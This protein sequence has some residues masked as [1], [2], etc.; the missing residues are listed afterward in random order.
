[1]PSQLAK[2][3]RYGN[4]LKKLIVFVLASA[5]LLT[6]CDIKGE[7]VGASTVIN[8]QCYTVVKNHEALHKSPT[9]RISIK[10]SELEISH[11]WQFHQVTNKKVQLTDKTIEI[12]YQLNNSFLKDGSYLT[13]KIQ[14]DRYTGDMKSEVINY[15]K[16]ANQEGFKVEAPQHYKEECEQLSKKF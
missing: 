9:Y 16:L 3:S 13:T 4:E 1:M 12:V 5:I 2:K 11:E 8:L 7:T 15:F 6:G 14:I 10:G